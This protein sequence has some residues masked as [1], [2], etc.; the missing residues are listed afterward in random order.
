MQCIVGHP[1]ILNRR[2]PPLS[3]AIFLVLEVVVLLSHALHNL[4]KQILVH[5]QSP[6]KFLRCIYCIIRKVVGVQQHGADVPM[7]I[8]VR[9]L[10]RQRAI[11]AGNDVVDLLLELHEEGEPYILVLL[12]GG[13][14]R[15]ILL[16]HFHHNLVI[17]I[18]SRWQGKW[19]N[20]LR[21]EWGVA[22][23]CA[24]AIC[25]RG[26]GNFARPWRDCV[27]GLQ[28]NFLAGGAKGELGRG[29]SSAAV[30]VPEGAR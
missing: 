6:P 22:C 29:V 18:H 28:S 19:P 21:V 26:G 1:C 11:P 24:A 27:G 20:T 23:E 13:G 17:D 16:Q 3:G 7:A 30:V 14:F 25:G 15:F 9:R 10:P 2:E 12:V 8:L 4:H 5:P